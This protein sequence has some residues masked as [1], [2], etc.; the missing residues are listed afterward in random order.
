M[1]NKI[2]ILEKR[3]D[4]IK[5]DYKTLTLLEMQ[6]KYEASESTMLRLF[7]KYN[8]TKKENYIDKRIGQQRINS[9]G[10]TMEVIEYNGSKNVKIKFYDDYNTIVNTNWDN[11][12]KGIT[13]NPN[14]RLGEKNISTEGYLMK[15]IYYNTNHNVIVEFQ[16]EYHAQVHTE[17]KHFKSGGVRNPYHKSC[18]EIGVRG[19]KYPCVIN[20]KPTKE[21]KIWNAMLQRCYDEKLKNKFI[22]YSDCKAIEDWLYYPNFYEWLISQENYHKW[23]NGDWNLDKDILVKRN[24]IYSPETCCLVPHNVNVLFVKQEP[25]RGKYPIGVQKIPSGMY[26]A[27]CSDPFEDKHSPHTRVLQYF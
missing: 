22:T 2:K 25:R 21:Y 24:K 5:K 27:S 1:G 7:R 8:I 11:F 26:L 12:D 17:Y 20:G 14:Y 4:E 19:D 3:I 15:I 13:E 18:W 16:D 6:E 23:K 10:F 9:Q